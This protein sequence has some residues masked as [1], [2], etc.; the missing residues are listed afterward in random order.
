MIIVTCLGNDVNEYKQWLE[1]GPE[2]D[3]L[4]PTACAVC[5]QAVTGFGWYRRYL[6]DEL[7]P[8]RRVRCSACRRT[9][10]V[11][12]SFMAPHRRYPMQVV[13]K[14]ASWRVAGNSWRQLSLELA[15]V[16]VK[17]MQRLVRRLAERGTV[18]VPWLLRGMRRLA[19]GFEV[20]PWL[21]RQASGGPLTRLLQVAAGFCAA[22]KTVDP[23]LVLEPGRLLEV[24]NV[25][26]NLGP[27][28][29][30]L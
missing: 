21:R 22:A 23:E 5:G 11:L 20:D 10:A 6:W 1:R 12:P 14:L 26:L 25:Y 7:I 3:R 30:W 24:C 27:A 17:T 13:E 2:R 4:L 8:I 28:A 9:H 19:P 18:A 16:P 29:C 15:E